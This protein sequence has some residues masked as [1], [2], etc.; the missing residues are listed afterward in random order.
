MRACVRACECAW[1]LKFADFGLACEGKG[2]YLQICARVLGGEGRGRSLWMLA[3]DWRGGF[4]RVVVLLAALC[5]DGAVCCCG[6]GLVMAA[7]LVLVACSGLTGTPRYLNL[8]PYT[9]KPKPSFRQDTL[10]LTPYTLNPKPSFGR[11]VISRAR[12]DT[13]NPKTFHLNPNS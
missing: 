4:L 1:L 7:V 5:Y 10:N 9:L 13:V 11:G 3:Q 2:A 8:T 12:R 6:G